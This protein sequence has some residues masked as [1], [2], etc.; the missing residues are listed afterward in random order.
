MLNTYSV[1]RPLGGLHVAELA[2]KAEVT[3]A[4]IRYYSRI[5]LLDPGRE[6][7]NGY[8]RFSASDLHRVGFIRQAQSLGLTIGDIKSILEALANGE[9]PCHQV[10]SLVKQRL[11]SIRDQIDELQATEA[12][13]T[14]ALGIWAEMNDP[15]PVDGELCPLI[16]RLETETHRVDNVSHL[17]ARKEKSD[18]TCHSQRKSGAM[19]SARA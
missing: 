10:K 19:Q 13:I 2:Q 11:I 4:T 17:P 14:N 16:E 15:A 8:R 6:A 1:A 18:H 9:I 5:G 3:P 12:R 7:E